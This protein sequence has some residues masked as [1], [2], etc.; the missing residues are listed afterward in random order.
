M[1]NSPGRRR[2][3]KENLTWPVSRNS[4]IDFENGCCHD[5]EKNEQKVI[6]L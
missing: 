5:F 1:L 4:W 3:I 2:S 6:N